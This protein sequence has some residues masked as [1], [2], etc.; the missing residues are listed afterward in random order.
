[1]IWNAEWAIVITSRGGT[2]AGILPQQGLVVWP[3]SYPHSGSQAHG[4]DTQGIRQGQK[5]QNVVVRSESSQ[6]MAW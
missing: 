1:M 6:V 4:P 3:D 5:G 2:I